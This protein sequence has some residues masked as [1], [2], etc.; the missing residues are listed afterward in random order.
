MIN[1]IL[2]RWHPVCFGP[3]CHSC[4]EDRPQCSLDKEHF[5]CFWCSVTTGFYGIGL[6]ALGPTPNLKDHTQSGPY[7]SNLFGMGCPTRSQRPQLTYTVALWVI[8]TN[9]PLHHSKVVIPLEWTSGNNQQTKIG[10]RVGKN[11]QQ[12]SDFY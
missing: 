11:H 5:L 10:M 4:C 8:E 12:S 6:S 2:T 3:R 1:L 7:P 9:K